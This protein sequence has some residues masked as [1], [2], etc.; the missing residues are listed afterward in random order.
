[1]SSRA[2][3]R[4]LGR[5]ARAAL[6]AGPA[7][8]FAAFDHS[9]YVETGAGVACLGGAQ[10]GLGPLNAVLDSFT[11][12][13]VGERIDVCLDGARGWAP[14]KTSGKAGVPALP[15]PQ[16]IR[17]PASAFLAWLEGT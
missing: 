2:E 8:V 9:C 5:F 14:T 7:T 1:M 10:L 12:L 15:I 16:A 17:I 11:P 13:G 4:V 3:A 6:E